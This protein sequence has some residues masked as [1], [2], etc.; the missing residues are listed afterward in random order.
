MRKPNNMFMGMKVVLCI[1]LVSAA[2]AALMIATPF[3][4]AFATAIFPI[5]IVVVGGVAIIWILGFTVNKGRAGVN[6]LKHIK[7]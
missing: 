3:I 7:R 6:K 1:V 4:I 2:C 5:L